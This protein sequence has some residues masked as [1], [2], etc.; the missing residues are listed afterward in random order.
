MCLCLK[1][2][3]YIIKNFCFTSIGYNF[4]A[5]FYIYL[6]YFKLI[7]KNIFYV[8]LQIKYNFCAVIN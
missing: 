3:F 6:F 1:T 5:M 7:K 2:F 8:F 4:I